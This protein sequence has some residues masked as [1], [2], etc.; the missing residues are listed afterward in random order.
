VLGLDEPV[1][2]KVRD[3]LVVGDAAGLREA[4]HAA[5]DLAVDVAVVGE[6]L[7]L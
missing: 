5:A 2:S 6:S 7:S 4:V 3:Q 1:G